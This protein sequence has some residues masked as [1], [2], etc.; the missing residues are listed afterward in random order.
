MPASRRPALIVCVS[1]MLALGP[2]LA[3]AEPD[4]EREFFGLLRV[5]D[6]TPFGFRRLDMRPSQA[7][8]E[9]AKRASVELDIA[10]QNTWSLSGGVDRYLGAR[11]ERGPLTE[12][13]VAAIRALPGENYL[14]DLELALVDIAFNYKLTERIGAYAVLAGATYT[15]GF[16][17]GFVEGFHRAFGFGTAA[18][19]G[20]TRN[21]V[22]VVIDLKGQQSTQLDAAPNSGFLDPVFGLRY[23]FARNPG[24]GNLVLE[25]AVKTPLAREGTFSTNRFDF[26]VQLTGQAFTRRH[27]FY[28]SGAAV[29]YAGAKEP[30]QPARVIP[31]AI[32]GYEHRWSQ[33]VNVILQGYASRS[34]FTRDQTELAELRSNKFQLSLGARRHLDN[35]YVS[36]A[37][38]ENLRYFNNTPDIGF[39]FGFGHAFN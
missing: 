27:A 33:K 34:V 17:D 25:T 8:F 5:R 29:Y 26:G 16:M 22:N 21:Q 3:A 9:P 4:G 28:V 31:T 1:A 10:Y 37:V 12:A 35:G 13:D 36:F 14:I 24:F 23:T 30:A 39:Q 20:L 18:R 11:T 32:V 19:P 38:T 7:A 15:G 2:S 6:L